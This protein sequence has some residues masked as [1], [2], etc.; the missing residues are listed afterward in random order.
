MPCVFR[1][2]MVGS[3]LLKEITGSAKEL[4]LDGYL[5][6]QF[7]FSMGTVIMSM[8]NKEQKDPSK[9]VANPPFDPSNFKIRGNAGMARHL[10]IKYWRIIHN[11]HDRPGIKAVRKVINGNYSSFLEHK[12]FMEAA[13]YQH[14]I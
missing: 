14:Y 3:D 13:H 11:P 4:V 1:N 9:R 7:K 8:F 6:S 12:N 2:E 10:P 5:E